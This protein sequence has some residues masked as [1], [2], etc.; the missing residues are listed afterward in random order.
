MAEEEGK[1]GAGT[2]C[3]TQSFFQL[4]DVGILVGLTFLLVASAQGAG[5]RQAVQ[6]LDAELGDAWG[7][8]RTAENKVS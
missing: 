2:T 4:G 6:G 5:V 8:G 3:P 7:V 1:R